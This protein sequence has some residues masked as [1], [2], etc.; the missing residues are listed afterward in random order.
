V[1]ESQASSSV[2]FVNSTVSELKGYDSVFSVFNA[3]KLDIKSSELFN[4]DAPIG[5]NIFGG[6]RL[7]IDNSHFKN[8]GQSV[9]ISTH[10]IGSSS[11]I[12]NS[13]FKDSVSAFEVYSHG[14]LKIDNSKIIGMSDVGIRMYGSST[15][16]INKSEI[17]SN[18]IGIQST[19]S[20]LSLT[21]SIV[22]NNKEY[23]LY[24]IAGT[25]VD[26]R[27]IIDPSQE[28]IYLPRKVIFLEG[29]TKTK[30]I[31]TS[32]LCCS[33]ILFIPGIQGS[34]LYKKQV[35][36][37]N[38]LWEPNLNSDVDKLYLD[39][40]GVS[41]D[42]TIYTR[43]IISKTNIGLGVF[44]QE[45]YQNFTDYLD[46]IQS[47]GLINTWK[48][49]PY[50][51]RRSPMNIAS[52]DQKLEEGFKKLE[53]EF[54]ELASS[55]RSHKVTLI[56]HSYGG[57]ISKYFLRYLHNKGKDT[58]VEN[59]ILIAVPESGA[60]ESIGAMLHG[61]DQEIAL[62]LMLDAETA[63]GLS[64]NMPSAYYLLP[65]SDLIS[66]INEPVIRNDVYSWFNNYNGFSVTNEQ[67]IDNFL[68]NLKNDRPY[69]KSLR[70][71]RLPLKLNLNLY[72]EVKQKR[73]DFD[74]D[75]FY[76]SLPINIYN[77]IGTGLDTVQSYVYTK[78]TCDDSL[79]AIIQ[80]YIDKYCGFNHDV[81]YT[82]KGDGTVLVGDMTKRW[83]NKYMFNIE[84]YNNEY[85]TNFSHADI[86]SSKSIQDLIS[87][88][89]KRDSL[90]VMPSYISVYHENDLEEGEDSY[91][92]SVD[93]G[94][95]MEAEDENGNI[96][97]YIPQVNSK[98]IRLIKTRIP[99][100]KYK[101]IGNKRKLITKKKVKK[102]KLVSKVVTKKPKAVKF[103]TFKSKKIKKNKSEK[104]DEIVFDQVPVTSESKIEVEILKASTTPAI[105]HIDIYG[106]G[107]VVII[108]P[109]YP[110][111][112]TTHEIVDIHK[113]ILDIQSKIREKESLRQMFKNRYTLRLKNIDYW[114][115][116]DKVLFAYLLSKR[117]SDSLSNI[118]KELNKKAPRYYRGGMSMGE[119][120]FLYPEWNKLT[121]AF[122]I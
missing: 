110:K 26:V 95:E 28:N 3:A 52:Q 46:T 109:T 107:N 45:I 10:D 4:I 91:E 56:G 47:S 67:E 31:A 70:D 88:I 16:E 94:L 75:N 100:S 63:R 82:N 71:T 87:L 20:L 115:L 25:F 37:E 64:L 119:S 22:K 85:Q 78:D 76:K 66:K 27:N 48:S 12:N 104:E 121:S 77:I 24:R 84:R 96:S 23:G 117:N 102:I 114:F 5:I 59:L 113:L 108:N 93:D 18:T 57:I 105:M 62:G 14:T 103:F 9:L 2:S 81:N 61:D 49:Y 106:D 120:L 15:V 17:S 1:L 97:G 73:K 43:D 53:S 36:G 99:N 65:N 111:A 79:A 39:S 92:Y 90:S 30:V 112:T 13:E 68:T 32:T 101:K 11:V 50:D 42:K 72:N 80:R 89:V 41:K 69:A 55:S 8:I 98:K 33:N 40:N 51:W 83:G 86:T 60:V 122:P 74:L 44:D 21:D 34:R 38:Q 6:G 35:L 54:E 58:L 7:E 29:D 116:K 19:E 118:L